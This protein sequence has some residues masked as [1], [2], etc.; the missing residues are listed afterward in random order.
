MKRTL[1]LSG[2]AGLVVAI[3]PVAAIQV[4]QTRQA[5]MDA[6][7]A[8]GRGTAVDKLVVERGFHEIYRL[9]EKKSSTCLDVQV[10]RSGFVGNQMEVSS[11]DYNPTLRR[12]G[13]T[14]AEFALQVVH[15]PR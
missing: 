3:Q 11:S 1:L 4:P 9:L 6:V 10:K 15:R 14:K 13:Q 12:V 8:G 2:L 5:F 7:A